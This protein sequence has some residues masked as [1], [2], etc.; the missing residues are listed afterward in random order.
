VRSHSKYVT[1]HGFG[2]SKFRNET[3]GMV[4][5]L[6][7]FVA[8]DAPVK[9][10]TLRI[11]NGSGRAR[12]LS[13]TGYCDWV[14]GELKASSL[15]HVSPEVDPLTGAIFA[16]NPFHSEFGSRIAFFDS[17][18]KLRAF[19]G[20]RTE[21]IGRN[22]NLSTPEAML[23]VRLS[24]RVGAGM[25]SCAAIQS[26]IDM[27]DGTEQTLTFSLGVGRD[28]EDVQ[29]LIK[30][31]GSNIAAGQALDDVTKFWEQTLSMVQVSTPDPS[32]DFLANGWLVYQTLACRIWARSGSYQSGGAFGFRDQLQDA[33]ALI[34]TAPNLLRA[35][36]LRCA[37]RQFREGDV[38][39]W[40]HP[41]SGRGVRT[42]FSDDYLWLPLAASR[43]VLSVGDT[44]VLDVKVEFLEGREVRPDE[45]GYMDLPGRSEEAV[46]F[47]E[48]C[49][50]AIRNS[51]ER[52]VNGL[53]LMGCGDWNDGMNLVGKG[54]K[55]E[56]VW[57]AF[58]LYDVLKEFA[59]VSDLREDHAFALFCRNSATELA[60]NIELK[61]WDGGWYRRAYFDDG[62]PLG[63]ASNAECQI[64]SLPQSWSVLSGAGSRERS[65]LAM[66]AVS[67]RLV[68]RKGRLVKLFDPPFSSSDLDP[69]YIKGYVPGVREN[70]GQYTHAAIW[71]AMAFVSLDEK[72]K[73]WEIFNLIN[74]INHTKT[75]QGVETYKVEPYVMAADVYAV[76]PHTGRGGWT[77]YTGSSG[78]MY[79]LVL[80][81]LLGVQLLIDRLYFKPC[82][83][84]EWA[85][86]TVNY[87]Y[88]STIYSLQFIKS[89]TADQKGSL[90]VGGVLQREKSLLL[91]DDTLDH[92]VEVYY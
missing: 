61:G 59:K 14:L 19:S 38:Q 66:A 5:E 83:P 68:D 76:A 4:T 2:F 37:S 88:R 33:M 15:L 65:E 92:K 41:P 28:V 47:Y 40:W 84:E 52:G 74:P 69:G 87:R 30:R 42:H 11:R 54:G 44:G 71:A 62:T 16:R 26:F 20:D 36:L 64:D 55:G 23:K 81:S 35:H 3:N 32:L 17:S 50:R 31:F 7:T 49:V 48:H 56:S 57:L 12:R 21:F 46:S 90:L 77:W 27:A 91:I 45:E 8:L 70:G 79:R 39:H 9:M 53:P 22:R 1:N 51:L 24:G 80:E 86:F 25:D 63:S 60:R 10:T 89:L 75:A 78:W 82:V 6:T 29:T 43:Y 85:G 18:H 73:A 13:I 72:Q 58:F 34:H 67:E